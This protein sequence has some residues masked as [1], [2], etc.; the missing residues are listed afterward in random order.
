MTEVT[1]HTGEHVH[2]TRFPVGRFGKK[3]GHLT[4]MTAFGGAKEA[5]PEQRELCRDLGAGWRSGDPDISHRKGL[6]GVCSG[7]KLSELELTLWN[8]LCCGEALDFA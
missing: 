3:R 5:K 1:E 8:P 6:K 2:V 4:L 7:L